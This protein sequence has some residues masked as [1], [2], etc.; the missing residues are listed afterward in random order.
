MREKDK[1]NQTMIFRCSESEKELIHKKAKEK[2]K[3]DSQYLLDSAMAGTE[4]R[5]DREKKKLH[6]IMEY[7]EI[8]NKSEIYLKSESCDSEKVK[9]MCLELIE[10]GKR[11]W[12]C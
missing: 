7:L 4:R 9:E 3:S 12:E 5:K 6:V 1:K 8:I 2:G 11:L 10:G